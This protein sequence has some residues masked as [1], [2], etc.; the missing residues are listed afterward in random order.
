MTNHTTGSAP[1]DNQIASAAAIIR[2]NAPAPIPIH[3]GVDT[4][5]VG[6]CGVAVGVGVT[7]GALVG[8]DVGVGVAVD[9]GT[10]QFSRDSY[11]LKRHVPVV[12]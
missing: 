5:A 3:V 11:P 2:S 10:V 8:V 9:P 6:N 1:G 12:L 7:R 4:P